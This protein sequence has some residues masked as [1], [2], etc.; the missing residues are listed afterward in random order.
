MASNVRFLDQVPISSFGDIQTATS[1]TANA[2]R[3]ISSGEE[4]AINSS[5]QLFVN[6]LWNQGTVTIAQGDAIFFGDLTL[7]RADSASFSSSTRGVWASGAL[8][9]PN[10]S[11]SNV[12]D[13]VTI[14]SLGNAVDFGDTTKTGNSAGCSNST[15]GIIGSCP[16]DSNVI[17]FITI[18]STGN[19]Q[20][21]GDQTISTRV[22][23]GAFS[24]P[25]RAIFGGGSDASVGN[26]IDYITISTTGN[27]VDFGDLTQERF[28]LTGCSNGHGGL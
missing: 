8:A 10:I 9:A 13:Y 18:S 14:S 27:A 12:I 11:L 28:R 3:F 2:V 26:T 19:S 15:R 4:V 16:G 25:T 5:E 21:F 24:S 1:T 7:S 17:E 6:D 23:M 20:D 22:I